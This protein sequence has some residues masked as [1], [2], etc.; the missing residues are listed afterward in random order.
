MKGRGRAAQ[1]AAIARNRRH[2]VI[3]RDLETWIIPGVTFCKPFRFLV[4]GEGTPEIG[5][6]VIARDLKTPETVPFKMRIT[7][8]KVKESSKRDYVSRIL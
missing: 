7:P 2:R 1:S 6:P 3:A 8:I 5:D 4:E